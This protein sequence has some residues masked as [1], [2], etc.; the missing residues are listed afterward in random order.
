MYWP[1]I[2]DDITK[3]VTNCET[4]LQFSANNRK[5]KPDNSL[6]HEVPRTPWTKLATDIFTF[7]NHNY[8]VMVDYTSKF[9]VV[10]KLS[11]M[12]ARVVTEI[13]KSIFSEYGLP[14]TIISD[15]GPCYVAEY[16]QQEMKK[17]GIAHVTT[18]PHYHQSNGMAEAYVK[19]IKGLLKKAKAT[20][21]DPHL[22]MMIYRTTPLGPNMPSPMEILHGRKARSDL[23]NS[24]AALRA[25]SILPANATENEH[26]ADENQLK[27]GQIVM[28][29]TPPEKNL[30]KSNSH[31][32]HWTQILSNLISRRC[33]LQKDA[34]TLEALQPKS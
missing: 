4:C 22:A 15:N 2:Y 13:I 33:D 12:T 9:P 19:I 32:I 24:A 7:D 11:S 34:P 30:A 17:L 14:T 1:G 10:R 16:F 29:L 18:S 8:L 6:S 27:E 5:E 26:K 28:F 21:E 31:K 23:P 3:M 25:Q 20:G